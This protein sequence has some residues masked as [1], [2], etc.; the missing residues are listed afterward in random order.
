MPTIKTSNLPTIQRLKFEDYAD[1]GDW[2]EALRLLVS[3]LN[4]FMTPIYN[5]LNGDV[6]Y[7]NLQAPQ[8]YTT[9]YTPTATSTPP[10]FANP[11]SRSPQSVVIGNVWSGVSSNHPTGSVQC[12]WHISGDSIVI[13]SII[14]LTNGT[15]YSLTFLVN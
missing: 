5:I 15:Q 6:E 9:T 11:I 12:F 1:A 4:L 8:V 10:A 13:D 7:Q 14:G 2:K 3:S